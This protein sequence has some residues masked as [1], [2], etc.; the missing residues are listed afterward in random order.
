M[1]QFSVVVR[2]HR[3]VG[4]NISVQGPGREGRDDTR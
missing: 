1:I 4:C 3:D 2:D